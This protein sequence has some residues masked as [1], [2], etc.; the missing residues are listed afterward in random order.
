MNSLSH[1]IE[2][3]SLRDFLKR[4]ERQNSQEMVQRSNT[5]SLEEAAVMFPNNVADEA[6]RHACKPVAGLDKV[7]MFTTSNGVALRSDRIKGQ[8]F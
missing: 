1:N 6:K 5:T 2:C 7:D 8:F 4:H 3:Q